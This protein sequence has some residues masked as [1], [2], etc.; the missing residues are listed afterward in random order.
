M[1]EVVISSFKEK[2]NV[3]LEEISAK[4]VV[5]SKIKTEN[6]QLKEQHLMMEKE[7]GLQ[8]VRIEKLQE[9][10]FSL[11]LNTINLLDK[12]KKKRR[13]FFSMI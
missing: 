1:S 10:F 3:L 4:N 13:R 8:K 12:T 6:Y 7:T 11:E 5:I 2:N 9:N